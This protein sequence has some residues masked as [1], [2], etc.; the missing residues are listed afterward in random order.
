MNSVTSMVSL[1]PPLN[2]GISVIGL[3]SSIP[4]ALVLLII[5][6]L[7]EAVYLH[8]YINRYPNLE[9][10]FKKAL[11]YSFII[12]AA[13]T[14]VGIPIAILFHYV[15]P[16]CGIS[17][18]LSFIL[19]LLIE[20]LL[21]VKILKETLAR[22]RIVK[23]VIKLNVISY[24]I[25]FV[26]Y[27]LFVTAQSTDK[28]NEDPRIQYR[29]T[30]TPT[31]QI[32]QPSPTAM[33]TAT[34]VPL[35]PE[36]AL[37]ALIDQWYTGIKCGGSGKKIQIGNCLV[38]W[39]A[40][41]DQLPADVSPD[42]VIIS[43][44]SQQNITLPGGQSA[45]EIILSINNEKIRIVTADDSSIAYLSPAIHNVQPTALDLIVQTCEQAVKDGKAVKAG[46]T[47]FPGDSLSQVFDT[48][49]LSPCYN[50]SGPNGAPLYDN[51]IDSIIDQLAAAHS[52]VLVYDEN[53]KPLGPDSIRP[54]EALFYFN[55]YAP[56]HHRK[57]LPTLTAA[58]V[59]LPWDTTTT[60]PTLLSCY[61]FT[62]THFH[63]GDGIV[64]A[65]GNKGEHIVLSPVNGVIT[66]AGFV[67]DFTG[68]EITI[69]TPFSRAGNQVYIDIVH[70]SGLVDGLGVGEMVTKGQ[71]LA[72][73]IRP[74]GSGNQETPE[75]SIDIAA[76]NGPK[77]ANPKSS[78]FAPRSYF[79][80]LELLADDLVTLS[81]GSFTLG[82]PCIGNPYQK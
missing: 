38:P 32:V 59:G 82:P 69:E 75:Y 50:E 6:V 15:I 46:F 47:F 81:P 12:N 4:Y 11:W 74:Y 3:I 9:L 62:D 52:P 60:K 18:I 22:D 41:Y 71:P 57:Y 63:A 43:V 19:T 48:G 77:G 65:Y 28:A 8:E 45:L 67:N 76:R 23:I 2:V 20:Y 21:L 29:A 34:A 14:L 72:K 24:I 30:A 55:K 36:Q 56:I 25:L 13:S 5:V 7:L 44:G 16:V 79:S 61:L 68:W 70:S 80:F 66:E 53:G 42:Y 10:P 35:T 54:G 49:H 64:Y 37:S 58:D 33:P 39:S 17:F 26:I 73:L 27:F 51:A 1:V 78:N 40:I 31:A